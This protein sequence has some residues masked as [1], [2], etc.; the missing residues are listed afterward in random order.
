MK[1]NNYLKWSNE[2][3]KRGHARIFE[4][5]MRRRHLNENRIVDML[6]DEGPEA[7][8]T[9][10]R[11]K[12]LQV[13]PSRHGYLDLLKN[14]FRLDY[15]QI[16]AMLWLAGIPPLLREEVTTILGDSGLFRDK[17]EN[18]LAI[19]AYKLLVYVIGNDLGMPVPPDEIQREPADH[20][21]DFRFI[22]KSLDNGQ[23][24]NI[25]GSPLMIEGQYRPLYPQ[26]WVWVVLQDSYSNYYLQSPPVNFLPDGRWVADNIIL[27]EG[28]T[29][30]HFVQ[31][32]ATGNAELTHKVARRE[33]GAFSDLPVDCEIIK[34]IRI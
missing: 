25:D 5:L 4:D 18:E 32:G 1:M 9:I 34:S 20:I 2:H 27:G 17:T 19:E 24:L 13:K 11:W 21:S 28:I 10:S 16:D 15:N 12:T 33:W 8:S 7:Q 3:K 22:L 14:I 29:A 30:V 26:P 6:G 23:L 31:V